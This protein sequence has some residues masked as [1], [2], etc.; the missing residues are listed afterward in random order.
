MKKKNILKKS[1]DGLRRAF[2]KGFLDQIAKETQ[3]TDY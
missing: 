2:H 1:K 3:L